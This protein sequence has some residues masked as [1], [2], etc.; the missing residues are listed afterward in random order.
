MNI[1]RGDNLSSGDCMKIS[2]R[3]CLFVIML[4][5]FWSC[6]SKGPSAGS[7]E[8]VLLLLKKHGGTDEVRGLYS[9]D[10]IK[11]MEKYM[12][13]SGMDGQ[14]AV[15]TLSFIAEDADYSVQNIVFTGDSCSMSLKFLRD[16]PEK[17]R[18]LLVKLTMVKENG[19]W[20]IDRSDDF[21]ELLKSQ[22]NRETE[23]Y[24][25]RIR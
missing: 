1:L 7:P 3:A 24:L 9:A 14:A 20:R 6:G 12:D 22:K 23:N 18:G 15:N 8:E 4:S 2:V 11:Q 17:S 21:K 25:N 16:G 13:S 19:N 5:A 10:T